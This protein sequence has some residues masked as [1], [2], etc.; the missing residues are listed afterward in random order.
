MSRSDFSAHFCLPIIRRRRIAQARQDY[1]D[2]RHNSLPS[3]PASRPWIV[4]AA[5][6]DREEKEPDLPL[7]GGGPLLR[8]TQEKEGGVRFIGRLSGDPVIA[9]RLAARQETGDPAAA[10]R[11]SLDLKAGGAQ[12]V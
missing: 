3:L 12:L 5:K 4:L 9:A 10:L 2:R 11:Q 1:F 7:P 6:C 8:A